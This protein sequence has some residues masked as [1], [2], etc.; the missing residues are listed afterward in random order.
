MLNPHGSGVFMQVC[1]YMYVHTGVFVQ[2]IFAS[3]ENQDWFADT[4]QSLIGSILN[5]AGKV[6]ML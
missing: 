1:L 4:G 3:S 5:A 6:A 2:V